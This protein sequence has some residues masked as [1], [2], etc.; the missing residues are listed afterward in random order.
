VLTTAWCATG[1]GPLWR[2]LVYETQL[3]QRVSAWTTNGR[4]GGETHIAI[5]L[6]TGSDPAAV[7]A[8]L[9]E[10][11]AKGIDERAIERAVTRREASTIWSL[12]TLMNR[13]KIIQRGMLY[14][15][16]PDMLAGELARYRLVTPDTVDAA[17]TRWLDPAH[18]IEVTTVPASAA[19]GS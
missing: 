9:D 4:L 15:H 2:R 8:I 6:K 7:R 16:D 17:I 11:C 3:A 12:S 10:E 5:D 19:S 18:G 1:T 14:A 13:V